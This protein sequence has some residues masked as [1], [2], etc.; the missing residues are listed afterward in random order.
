MLVKLAYFP[1]LS[2]ELK[3]ANK[4]VYVTVLVGENLVG[5]F[6][7]LASTSLAMLARFLANIKKLPPKIFSLQYRVVH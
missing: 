7:I 3:K 6:L 5:R 4:I 1:P 2:T